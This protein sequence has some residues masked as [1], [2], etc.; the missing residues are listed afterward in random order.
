MAKGNLDSKKKILIIFAVAIIIGIILSFRVGIIQFIE[1][2]KWKEK[3]EKQQYVSRKI[4][5]NRGTIFDRSGKIILAESST[6]R[7]VT[8]NPLNIEN[9]NK[10]K[11]AKI[12]SQIFEIEYEK[13]LK[14]VNKNSMIE[15]IAKRVDKEKTDDLRR[16]MEENSIF[17]GIN[18][19]E[20][21]KITLT[22]DSYYTSLVNEKSDGS[23]LINGTYNWTIVH[24][25]IIPDSDS[26]PDTGSARGILNSYSLLL[27]LS[28]ILS[29][30]L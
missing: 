25:E 1:G 18:I 28:L 23:N 20:D 17:K 22:G 21:S 15:S 14:K 11:V 9:E 27:S 29:I 24:E 2:E 19:D 12:L 5:A 26:N 6:V 16:W 10:E 4:T 3:S 13:A 7:S 30:I 8:I